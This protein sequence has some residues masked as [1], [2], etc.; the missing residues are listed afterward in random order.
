MLRCFVIVLVV[1]GSVRAAPPVLEPHDEAI[2]AGLVY[3]AANQGADGS[4]SSRTGKDPAVTSLA[5]M[6]FLSAGH[7]PGE[8][9]YAKNIEAGVRYVLG[10]QQ[11]NGLLAL[12][13]QGS[14]EMYQHGICTLML[15][16]VVGMMPDRVKARQLRDQL[17]L[18]VKIVLKAQVRDG[19]DRGGWRY[20]LGSTD[21]DVS[22]S[23]WQLM[24]LRAAKNVGCDVP[25]APVEQ[26][27]GYIKRC[28]DP[29]SGGYRYQRFGG[30]T[31]PCTGTAVLAL[32]LIG[33]EHH[34]SIESLKAGGYL[35]KTPLNPRQQHFFY[36]IYYTSQAMFQLGDNYWSVYRKNLHELLL[37][38]NPLKAA[39]CW[40]GW[41]WDDANV[42]P[43]YCTAMAILALTVEYR[44]LP[45]Y[46]RDEEPRTK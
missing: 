14:M 1:A 19:E 38:Q 10:A 11:R 37:T 28:H 21:A 30:V 5:V 44:F 8:G 33:K 36:G 24:A 42:G 45:I 23:G 43:S 6:A 9:P 17:E 7:V 15:C 18:A 46:Q 3:L 40:T 34:Q 25:Y 39:G 27:V 20:T 32:E 2:N 12:A 26:A 29:V 13:N 35:L 22:V 31:V 4:W 16:E 41:G